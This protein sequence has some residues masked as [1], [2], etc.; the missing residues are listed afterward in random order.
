MDYKNGYSIALTVR[1]EKKKKRRQ[2]I[3][4]EELFLA[5]RLSVYMSDVRLIC[6]RCHKQMK[7]KQ[8]TK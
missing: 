2:I 5:L 1:V 6:D 4:D 7:V 8:I 3:I